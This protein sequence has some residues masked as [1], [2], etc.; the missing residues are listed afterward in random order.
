MKQKP[1][2]LFLCAERQYGQNFSAGFHAADVFFRRFTERGAA[3]SDNYVLSIAALI[4]T[5]FALSVK[6]PVKTL[7][8]FPKLVKISSVPIG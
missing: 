7:C 3:L 4:P 2:L 5:V 6:T 1:F 8:Q